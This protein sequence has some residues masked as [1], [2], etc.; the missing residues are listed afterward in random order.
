MAGSIVS[1]KT[2]IRVFQF[3]EATAFSNSAAIMVVLSFFHYNFSALL[4]F[5]RT[6]EV[7]TIKL[8]K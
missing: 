6:V 8:S 2:N 5:T 3:W 1:H 7:K 4:N